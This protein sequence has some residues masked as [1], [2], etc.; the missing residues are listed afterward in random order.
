VM[1]RG[2]IQALI[3]SGRRVPEDVKVI[4]YDDSSVAASGSPALTTVRVPFAQIGASMARLVFERAETPDRPQRR[5]TMDTELIARD[6][7]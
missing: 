7:T 4:G 3:E 2:A 1:A 6:S 5:I